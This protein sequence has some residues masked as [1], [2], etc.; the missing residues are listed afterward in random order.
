MWHRLGVLDGVDMINRS[1]SIAEGATVR[2][3]S[4]VALTLSYNNLVAIADRSITVNGQAV[5]YSVPGPKSRTR[6]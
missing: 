6:N 4:T 5:T 3:S 2:P 1:Q